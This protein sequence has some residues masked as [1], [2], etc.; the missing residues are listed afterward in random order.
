MPERSVAG[1]IASRLEYHGVTVICALTSPSAHSRLEVRRMCRRFIEVHVSTP[2][3]ECERRDPKGLYATA[4]RGELVD[5]V[6]IHIPYE[7][8]PRSE[9]VLDTTNQTIAQSVAWVLERRARFAR[10]A[11]AADRDARLPEPFD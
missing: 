5:V 11:A 8:S 6:G 9:I 7:P 10:R 3:A 2:L 1:F 4:R